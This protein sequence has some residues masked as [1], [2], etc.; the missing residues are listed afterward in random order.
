MKCKE[1]KPA[2]ATRLMKYFKVPDRL[3]K[4]KDHECVYGADY[5]SD[6]CG[7]VKVLSVTPV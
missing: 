7:S 6:N 5:L 4:I 2:V 3:K 1:K